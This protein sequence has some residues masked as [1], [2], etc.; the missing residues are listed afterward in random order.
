PAEILAYANAH[1][2]L[3]HAAHLQ[4]GEYKA[5]T[6]LIGYPD[7]AVFAAWK[8]LEGFGEE[9]LDHFMNDLGSTESLDDGNPI[10]LLRKK[11]KDDTE[12]VDPMPKHHALAYVT[13]VFNAWRLKQ[14]MKRL[15]LR[16]EEPWPRFA[17]TAVDTE[18]AA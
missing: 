16:T 1:P 13:K 6:K 14:P 10:V 9:A 4:I 5:A 3:A 15:F 18:A 11:F 8:M 7:I 17:D 2:Q 12:S